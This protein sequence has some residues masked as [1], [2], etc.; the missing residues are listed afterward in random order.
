ML[1]TSGFISIFGSGE[2]Q[3]GLLQMVQVEVGVARGVYEL[4]SLE[5]RHLRHHHQQQG[6]GRNVE[7]HSEESVG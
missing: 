5:P 3:A 4:A 1:L 6:I 7:R 2:L